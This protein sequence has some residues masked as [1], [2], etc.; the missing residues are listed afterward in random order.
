MKGGAN[1]SVQT[2]MMVEQ[3]IES[4]R[5]HGISLEPGIRN[6]ADGNCAF[7]SVLHNI[8][9]RD[10]FPI[11]LNKQINFYRNTWVTQ[12][13]KDVDATVGAGYTEEEKRENWE[14]LKHSGVY[15]IP[16]F[17]DLVINGI[18]KGCH[19]NI[20]IFNTSK[21]AAD[22]IYVVQANEFG[23]N[24][25]SDIPVVLAY[26]QV[27]YESLHPSSIEDIE[28]TK[29]LMHSYINGQ[30]HFKKSDITFLIS[31]YTYRESRKEVAKKSQRY[32]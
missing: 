22:P 11:K 28:K 14:R 19:K 31:E 12:L 10:C 1:S 8:N 9:Y 16:F 27:H 17:G 3:A 21:E 23:G 2:P 7:E 20:L 18:A 15:D 24:A 4:A 13:E 29:I 30:Y 32:G 6:K 26:N 25:D 5:K